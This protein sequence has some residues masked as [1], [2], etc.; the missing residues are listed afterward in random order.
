[1]SD[2]EKRKADHI[3]VSLEEDVANSHNYWDDLHLI[4][5]SLPEVDLDEIDTTTV[6]FGRK[7]SAPLMVTAITGGYNDA[8]K[9]NLNLAEACASLGI[10]LGIGSQRAAIER[11]DR[12]SYE[13]IRDVGVPLVV[14]NLGAP[15]LIPQA[16]KEAFGT[17][18]AREAMEMVGADVLAVHLNY[19]QE[20]AQPEGDTRARGCLDAIR[21]LAREV[22]CIAKET[23]AGI[24]RET[25]LRLKGAGV[26][27][28]DISGTSGTS[29][30]KVEL[31]RSRRMGNARCVAIGET[32]AEWGIPAP[33]SVRLA[34]VGLPIIASGGIVD[35]L[36]AAK[37]IATG[38]QCAGL[39]RAVLKDAMISAE[40]AE[41]RLRTIIE[42]LKVGMFLTGSSTVQQLASKKV[43][44]TGP[45]REWGLEMEVI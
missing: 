4:H 9:V 14:A 19:L 3:Q 38:A 43:V 1:M 42:E 23:G 21:S 34:Q 26:I 8:T 7:L 2:I 16:H 31:H 18:Q 35:G 44:F 29:F 11:G 24:S 10:A 15:Q 20:V 41:E 33:I 6:L 32:F 12:A 36:K 45:A 17:E 39:A 22:P 27:G 13:V 28:F 30:S 40:A 5:D 37:S 25:A